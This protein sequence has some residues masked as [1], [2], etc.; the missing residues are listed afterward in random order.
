MGPVSGEWAEPRPYL[1][2]DT[3]GM[4]RCGNC[5]RTTSILADKCHE[6][7]FIDG[8]PDRGCGVEFTQITSPFEEHRDYCEQQRPDLEY[9]VLR[10]G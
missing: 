3:P 6:P 10:W 2:V 4:S 7:S 9:K 5:D 1:R 8:A